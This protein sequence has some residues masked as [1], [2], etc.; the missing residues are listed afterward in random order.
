MADDVSDDLASN[1]K[2]LRQHL[3]TI[4]NVLVSMKDIHSDA[5]SHVRPLEDTANSFNDGVRKVKNT[6][7]TS[8]RDNFLELSQRQM[9]SQVAYAV[10]RALKRNL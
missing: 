4:E 10:N 9:W 8:S 5:K 1:M 6:K 7:K 3:L 2:Q